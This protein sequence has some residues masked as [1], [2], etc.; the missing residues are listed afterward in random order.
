MKLTKASHKAVKYACLNFHYAKAVPSV[1]LAYNVFNG[2]GEWCGVICY[3]AG[4]TPN[5]VKTYNLK[6]GQVVELVRMALNG[7]QESTTKAMAISMK[8][9]KKDAPNV[10]LAIS[11]ADSEQNHFGTIYQATNWTYTGFSVDKNLILNGVRTHPRSAVAKYGTRSKSQLE[12]KGVDVKVIKTLPK[13]KYI[14]PLHKSMIPLCKSLAQPYPKK[15]AQE[16]N[17]DKRPASSRETGGS[18]PTLALKKTEKEQ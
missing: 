11:F 4:A 9:L 1:Q 16:V 3:G 17:E 8:L 15:Q 10:R 13:W 14:Y 18:S 5:L 2:S 6:Q 12:K 7:K